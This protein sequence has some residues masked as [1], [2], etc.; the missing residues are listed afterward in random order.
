VEALATG[1]QTAP[2]RLTG[3]VPGREKPESAGGPAGAALLSGLVAN[4]VFRRF[5]MNVRLGAVLAVL[6]LGLLVAADKAKD[7]AKDDQKAIQGTWTAVSV[8][9]G[10]EKQPED[11]VKDAR[12]TFEAGGKAS[13]KHG[14]K[15][16]QLTYELDAT[17]DPKQITVKGEDGKT[18]RGIYK[19]DGD[20]LTICMGEEDSNERP[21]E[22]STKAGSKAHL[23]VLKREK[24]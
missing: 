5:A 11:K 4:G 15:E 8:E 9:Q 14:D 23:V 3:D 24:K 1:A 19:I 22:F 16:K 7:D 13:L 6:A 20:T 10:G 2:A 17:K 18:Q 21:T 12:I